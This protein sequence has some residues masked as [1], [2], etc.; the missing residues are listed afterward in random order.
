MAAIVARRVAPERIHLQRA[1]H[2]LG[3]E[4][5]ANVLRSPQVVGP[6]LPNQPLSPSRGPRISMARKRVMVYNAL[7][8][9]ECHDAVS[10]APAPPC[11]Q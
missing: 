5:V 1:F 2:A 10:D 9:G 7:V 3:W 8:R 11:N 4:W 6:A